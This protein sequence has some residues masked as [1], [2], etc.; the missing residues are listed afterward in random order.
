MATRFP[1]MLSL[2]TTLL[3]LFG[4]A[5]FTYQYLLGKQARSITN[6]ARRVLQ[7]YHLTRLEKPAEYGITIDQVTA[8]NDQVPALLVHSNGQPSEKGALLRAQ[9]TE[10]GITPPLLTEI[11]QP[12]AT[13]ILLHGRHGRKEDL[14]PVAE[15][16]CAVG[17]RCLIPDLPAHGDSPFE[18]CH[19]SGGE[20]EKSL[21]A[22][23][24]Q[25]IATKHQFTNDPV[26]L[27]GM[28]MGGAYLTRAAHSDPALWSALCI[29]C[30]FPSL[31]AV[32]EEKAG[33]FFARQVSKKIVTLGGTH[34]EKINSAQ[35]AKTITT[36]LLML[37]GEED[38]LIPQRQGQ[39]FFDSFAST[40]KEFITVKGA[41]HNNILTTPE[42]LYLKMSLFLL[43]QTKN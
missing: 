36:P 27:W 40:E 13:V 12:T 17:F 22:N 37:H 14:L 19:F 16:F 10:A 21:L 43:K 41:G 28:S 31:E 24:Y 23:L 11:H 29:I 30:S 33:A 25:E 8:C 5:I 26:A 32:M 7:D 4:L 18:I 39:R 6:P 3:I 15:R 42:P 35:L 1:K 2:C 20:S 34:P 38:T 9:M